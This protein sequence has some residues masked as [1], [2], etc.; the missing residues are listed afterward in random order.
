MQSMRV[1]RMRTTP[2]TQL[3]VMRPAF[4]SFTPPTTENLSSCAFVFTANNIFDLTTLKPV[5]DVILSY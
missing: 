4:S 1:M 5:G 2:D 3:C